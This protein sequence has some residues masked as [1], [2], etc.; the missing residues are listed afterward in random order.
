MADLRAW[1]IVVD[2]GNDTDP[3]EA[4]TTIT[5]ALRASGHSPRTTTLETN[6]YKANLLPHDHTLPHV[7]RLPRI[8]TPEHARGSRRGG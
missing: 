3:H 1:T 6:A 4:A 8:G 5:T 2:L 7:K